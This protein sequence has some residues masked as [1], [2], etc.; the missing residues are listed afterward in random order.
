MPQSVIQATIC[1]G[2]LKSQFM[3]NQD[4]A[5]ALY[6]LPV[7][8]RKVHRADDLQKEKTRINPSKI[9]FADCNKRAEGLNHVIVKGEIVVKTAA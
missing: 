4:T 8:N 2:E 9:D 1:I 5:S 3:S 6:P 7:R